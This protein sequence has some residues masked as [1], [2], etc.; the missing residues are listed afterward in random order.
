MGRNKDIS[1]GVKIT[2]NA[3][4]FK[5]ASE[6][7]AKAV[8]KLH[9]KSKAGSSGI[10]GAFKSL[11]GALDGLSPA[12][13]RAT[14]GAAALGK[15]L[16]A[17]LANP[18]VA[19]IA[20]IVAALVAV[21]AAFKS[22]DKGAT[23]FAARFEQI[24][25]VLDVVRQ[26]LVV[27]AE[28]IGHVFKGEWKEAGEAFRR[29]VEAV[30]DQMKEAAEAAYA[31]TYAIDQ[32][33]DSENNYI[34]QSA[35]NRR[36]IAQLEFKAQ[37][38]RLSPEE[39]KQ[40]LQ[41]AMAIA[42]EELNMQKNYA[43]RRLDEELKYLAEKNNVRAEDLMR[44]IEMSDAE[45]ANAS[46]ALQAAR[47]NNEKKFKD[48]EDFYA[49]WIDLDTKFFE[50]QKRNMSRMTGFMEQEAKALAEKIKGIQKNVK[51]GSF[52]LPG[53]TPEVPSAVGGTIQS[54]GYMVKA[55]AG[56][57]ILASQL[58]DEL[59]EMENMLIAGR[60]M[61]VDLGTQLIEGLGEALAGGD[62]N[63]GEALLSSIAQ[64]LSQFGKLL[65]ALGLGL[66]AFKTSLA[67]LNPVVAIAAGAALIA[68]A[69]AIR[70]LISRQSG[71][72]RGGSSYAGGGGY[73]PVPKELTVNV[74]VQGE[75]SG[76]DLKIVQ[77]RN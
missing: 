38:R 17:L 63:I 76:R 47:N 59:A 10:S 43:K 33:E 5:A 74:K 50:E 29:S 67:T 57:S 60:D 40:A 16:L 35:T 62:I 51:E 8:E 25:A 21:V 77:R 34:S 20:G 9:A 18:I 4:G 11:G 39:R 46:A 3:K 61:A 19:I 14:Q 58:E 75:I 42:E 1:V 71:G 73:S 52:T 72:G 41:T 64:F 69:G 2:G 54:T 48:L 53:M 32:L 65:I 27:V 66:E 45:Q 12:F 55:G 31:Y 28:A 22:T 23:E 68:T 70:G 49:K 30:G 13:S 26:R 37:D 36:K 24:K 7:A 15:Q 44:Y 6:D 56:K